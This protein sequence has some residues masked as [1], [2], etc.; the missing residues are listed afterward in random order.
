Y[1]EDRPRYGG[2]QIKVQAP[3][4]QLSPE[5][6]RKNSGAAEKDRE[7]Y[8]VQ[9]EDAREHE[10]HLGQ[11]LA[12]PQPNEQQRSIVEGHRVVRFAVRV[13]VRRPFVQLWRTSH[14]ESAPE[15]LIRLTEQG[16]DLIGF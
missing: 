16:N 13:E 15:F 2:Q 8:E 3:G 1:G 4:E 14:P 7:P 10:Q 12:A 6:G 9:V 11:I 5:Q